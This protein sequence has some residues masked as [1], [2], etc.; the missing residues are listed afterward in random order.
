MNTFKPVFADFSLKNPDFRIFYVICPLFA[1]FLLIFSH[2][3]PL[4]YILSPLFHILSPFFSIF[5]N[6]FPASNKFLLFLAFTCIMPPMT[7]SAD[8][9]TP[10]TLTPRWYYNSI[11]E[12]CHLFMF[13]VPITPPPK[14]ANSNNFETKE[15]CESYCALRC[16]RGIP[17]YSTATRFDNE[18]AT[19]CNPG[20]CTANY[21]C[22][23]HNFGKNLCCPKN[24]KFLHSNQFIKKNQQNKPKNQQHFRLLLT[25]KYLNYSINGRPV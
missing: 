12:T 9:T 11:T 17:E 13:F 14:V 8:A 24:S 15:Q 1:Y 4:F 7:G 25:K 10:G 21:E 2:F 5:G 22:H 16:K 19:N 20:G 23:P 18:V 3:E 6:L